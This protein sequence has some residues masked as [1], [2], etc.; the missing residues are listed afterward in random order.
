MKTRSGLL[1]LLLVGACDKAS[2]GLYEGS[3][4]EDDGPPAGSSGSGETDVDMD[5]DSATSGGGMVGDVVDCA[6]LEGKEVLEPAGD[7]NA[8][9][10]PVAHCSPRSSGAGDYRCCSDDPTT[11]GGGPPAYAGHNI[12]N[13]E[14]PLFSGPSNDL[15]TSGMCVRT[16]AI[17]SGSGLLDPD[18]CPIPCNPTWDQ[19]E[20]DA[21][22]SPGRTCCQTRVLDPNDCI[23]VDGLWRPVTG[24]D[25]LTGRSTWTPSSHATHQDPGG[26]GCDGIAGGDMDVFLACVETLTVADQRGY[27]MALLPDQVC[28]ADAPG[29]L[30]ACD[31]INMGLIP[32]P[33]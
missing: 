33:V 22:C 30:D 16:S 26:S 5:V 1:C 18:G 31:Q 10:F 12:P 7:L 11:M 8:L 2:V 32:P 3:T 14:T 24:A 28:P 23:L 29:Y 25:I 17:P 6:T 27:C 21:V 4:G 9:G 20:T 15:G 13:G 19:E